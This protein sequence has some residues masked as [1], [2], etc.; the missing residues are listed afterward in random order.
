MSTPHVYAPMSMSHVGVTPAVRPKG[1]SMSVSAQTYCRPPLILRGARRLMVLLLLGVGDPAI[2]QSV[3]DVQLVLAVDTSGSVNQARFDLQMRGYAAAFRDPRILQAIR[4]GK[5]QSIAITMVQ[6][7]DPSAQVQVVPWTRINDEASAGA[8]AALIDETP[9]RLS[10][11]G[12]S[13][14]GAIDYAMKL[15]PEAP[16]QGLRRAIDISGDG[17]NNSGRP[18]ARARDEAV[19]AGATINGLPILE[20]EPNLDHYFRDNVIGGPGAFMIVADRFDNFADAILKKLIIEIVAKDGAP[21]PVFVGK[22]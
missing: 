12:T 20:L 17:S 16:F 2:A 13:I 5:T 22:K 10:G 6:W 11:G 18:A 4:G 3:V 15:F 1:N 7:S 21:A 8:V 9:R 14:S 19:A